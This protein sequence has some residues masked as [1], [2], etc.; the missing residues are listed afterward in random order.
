MNRPKAIGIDLGTTFSS[1]GVVDETGQPRIVNNRMGEPLTP[2]VIYFGGEEPL[3]GEEAKAMQGAGEED[4]AS[5]FKRSMGNPNYEVAFKGRSY[6]ATELSAILLKSLKADAEAELGTEVTQAVITVPAYFDDPQRKATIEAGKIAGLEVL[7]IINEPTAAAQA[8][9]VHK[10]ESEQTVLVY[11]LGGGTFDVSL[12]R[13]TNKSMIV[14]GTDGEH[15]LGG[16]DWDERIAMYLGQK[17]SD[18]NGVNPLDDAIAYNDLMVSCEEAKKRLSG[19]DRARISITH[20]GVKETYD[21][22]RAEFDEMTKDLMERTQQLTEKVLAELGMTWDRIDGVI[23]VGGSTR[24]PMVREWVEE[25]SGKKP[26]AG[27]NVDEAVAL[28]AAVEAGVA[29]AERMGYTLPG[30]KDK[31]DVMSHSLGM[32]AEN[33]DCS[34]YI[35]SI[36]IPKNKPI[37]FSATRSYELKTHERIEN[38]FNVFLLQGESQSPLDCTV[39]GNYVFSGINHISEKA[40]GITVAYSYDMNG[41]VNVEAREES[42]GRMLPCTV[43]PVPDDLSWLDRPPELE[44]I[45]VEEPVMP[46]SEP[47]LPWPGRKKKESRLLGLSDATGSM[48]GLWD[49]TKRHIKEMISR[50]NEFGSFEIKWVAYRDYCDG[51]GILESSAWHRKPEPLLRFIDSISCY[52][53]GDFPEAVEKAL[54]YAVKDKKVSRIVLIGDAPPHPE[55][56]YANQ[57]MKLAKQGKPVF[58]FVVG[59]DPE[60]TETFK[61][62][63]EITGGVSTQLNSADDLLD[64]VVLTMADEMGGKESVE[65]YLGKYGVLMSEGGKRYAKVLVSRIL[66]EASPG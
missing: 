56:D 18:D 55:R 22:T 37:P 27:V 28:G 65:R 32:V 33:E 63:A 35:N 9:G 14:I 60:T 62:I 11:D 25:M 10:K 20:E 42:T 7:R 8:Y 41:V 4:V 1:V 54:Q 31:I 19:M 13:I 40:A 57:A 26:I 38:K 52:G 39:L 15:E 2:S 34:R 43:D 51:A 36:I 66:K 21:L 59:Y 30:V 50:I 58:S 61:R 12:V 45:V 46:H 23:L 64:M 17:F 6:T 48:I 29:T 24:M 5:F 49:S 3:V 53:G 44:E 47:R 16:K